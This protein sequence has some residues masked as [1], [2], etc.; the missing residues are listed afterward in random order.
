[1]KDYRDP[2]NELKVKSPVSEVEVEEGALSSCYWAE[3]ENAEIM[4]ESR[5]DSTGVQEGECH[6]PT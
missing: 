1:M 2:G 4:A 5:K 6:S 3:G